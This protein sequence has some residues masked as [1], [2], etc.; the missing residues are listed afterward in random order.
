MLTSKVDK[1]YGKNLPYKMI[2]TYFSE[3]LASQRITLAK[4]DLRKT[5]LTKKLLKSQ[6]T[7]FL[8]F[9]TSSFQCIF[10]IKN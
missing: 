2:Y 5:T 10:Q 4:V 3:T 8:S 1:K 7:N 6:I 9:K